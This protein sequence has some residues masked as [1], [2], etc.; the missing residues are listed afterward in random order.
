MILPWKNY[1]AKRGLDINDKL[2]YNK[3]IIPKLNSKYFVFE[4]FILRLNKYF[5]TLL[6]I[7][8][9]TAKIWKAIYQIQ[10][11]Q[12][13]KLIILTFQRRQI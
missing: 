2:T 4:K 11:V 3:D 5:E 10:I 6:P 1:L 8:W 9:K 7:Y 13:L 12:L